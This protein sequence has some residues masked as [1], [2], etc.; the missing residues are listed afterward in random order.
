MRVAKLQK[1]RFE[2]LMSSQEHVIVPIPHSAKAHLCKKDGT[3]CIA[4]F[5][6]LMLAAINLDDQSGFHADKVGDV[7][8][9]GMLATELESM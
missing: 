6:F 9:N 8:R 7:W 5:I 1:D 2:N 4:C 3:L